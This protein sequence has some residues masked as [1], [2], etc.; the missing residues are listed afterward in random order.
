MVNFARM[1][2]SRFKWHLEASPLGYQA[3][4]NEFETRWSSV[5]Y[6]GT[7]QTSQRIPK[8]KVTCS[9]RLARHLRYSI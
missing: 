1:R 5:P 6:K 7:S 4:V 2:R 3:N 8:K 9:D